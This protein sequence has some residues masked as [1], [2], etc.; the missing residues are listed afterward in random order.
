MLRELGIKDF[1]L[2]RDVDLEFRQGMT[3][4]TGETGAGKTQCLEAL[5]AALGAR[6]GDDA[7]SKG[8]S[9]AVLSAV[10]DLADRPDVISVLRDEGWLEDDETEIVL[11]RTIEK[12]G[13]SRGRLNGRRVP[14]GTLQSVGDRIVD[15]LGQN[16]RA[17]ILNRPA[18]EVLD[19]LGD[20]AHQQLV[21]SVRER[22][23]DWQEAKSAYE[24][25]KAEIA[26]AEERRELAEFQHAELHKADLKPGEENELTKEVELLE[27]A[28]ERIEAALT[29][30]EKLA[31]D[32][33]ETPSARDYL[34]QAL[35]EVEKLASADDELKGEA[36]RLRETVFLV[37]ELADTL[38]RSAEN[39]VD[40]PER[41]AWVEERLATLHRLKRKYKRDESGLIE[42]RNR[43][44]AELDRVETATER[45]KELA[46]KRD[47][48]RDEYLG[49]A[50]RLSK[51]RSRL[52]KKIS[53]EVK[54]H[55]TDLDL[56]NATFTA[57]QESHPDDEK[58]YRADGYDRVELLI[59]T[60]PAQ[61]PAPL[62]KAASGGELSR[63]LMALK[64]VL[65][66]RDRVPVLVF[67]EA[68]AG[69]G[70]ET[71]FRVGEK[72]RELGRSHQL[73]IV[74]HLPQIASQAD[75]HWVIEKSTKKAGTHA[76]ARYV[77][78]EDRVEEI[79]RML[80]ARGDRKALD[81]LAR[82]L[83]KNS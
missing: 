6:S 67:D 23:S 65:A 39:I 72:L 25:E 37:E 33:D 54:G 61:E 58:M 38:R 17:D 77:D 26:R 14:T 10:F 7:V 21:N 49:E 13:R 80:G 24:L 70:G 35:D 60:N 82:S 5:M 11:E 44:A 69:I 68:E 22:F 29:A 31:S 16:A 52:A 78:G 32:D 56:P 46:E 20:E 45:L 59:A 64:T 66:K 74:S 83:L 62:K 51:S 34:Q 2:L 57:E 19:S 73:I 47:R 76:N 48:A 42:L 8:A 4:L 12:G 27:S 50:D 63:L 75:G 79:C 28:K 81:K 30:A 40:D 9:K 18:L 15:L 43:L 3:V 55:L 71:A 41:R 36:F 1:K 53:R